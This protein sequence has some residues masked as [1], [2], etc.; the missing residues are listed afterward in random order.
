[1]F[2]YHRQIY[3]FIKKKLFS[4]K[5]KSSFINKINSDPNLL[6]LDEKLHAF[7]YLCH[8]LEKAT[9]NKFDENNVRGLKKY[10]QAKLIFRYLEISEWKD[11]PDVKWGKEILDIYF[12]WKNNQYEFEQEKDKDLKK[13]SDFKK[14]L[15]NRRSVRFWNSKS[16]PIS[17]ILNIIEMGTMAPTSCNRQAY[18]IIVVD[19]IDKNCNSEGAVNR[20][21]IAKAPYIIYIAIDR[22]LYPEKFAPAIDAGIIAQN[23]MLAITHFGYGGCPM[24]HSES[25]NQKKL[26]KV[27]NIGSHQYIYIAI[28]FGVP[29]ESPKI[30]L[31]APVSMVSNIINLD[32]KIIA[33]A[34]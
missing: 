20:A 15:Y 22:R 33:E 4:S 9:K 6:T 13:E 3:R 12:K 32:A 5:E 11:S 28:P 29:S 23:L 26:R 24:Y 34:M 18:R 7:R 19:N 10:E 30:P 17:V 2:N 21:M 31:R 16:I 14:V 8:Q 25:Y 27:L 1:M